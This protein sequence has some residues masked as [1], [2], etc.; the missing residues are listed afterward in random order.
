MATPSGVNRSGWPWDNTHSFRTAYS[1]SGV[2]R[3]SLSPATI[4]AA[5]TKAWEPNCGMQL[6][7]IDFTPL[8]AGGQAPIA[9]SL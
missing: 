3:R 1:V 6:S 5:M 2:R 4:A 8:T 9:R 7:G